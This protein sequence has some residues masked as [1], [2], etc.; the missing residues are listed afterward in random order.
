MA[1]IIVDD[2]IFSLE[3]LKAFLM[4]AGYLDIITVQSATELYELVDGHLERGIVEIDLILM[5][6]VMPEIDGIEACRNVKKR[7]WLV[8]VPVIMVTA[9]TEIDGLQLAFSAGAMDYIKK[10]L[11]RVELLARV[12]SALKLKYETY[13]RKA[14]EAEL[15]EVTCQ[16]KA[17]NERL[18]NLSFIDGLTGIANR[19]RFDEGLL[20]ECR[21]SKRENSPLSLIILDIDYFKAF[22]DTYGH[23]K[24]DDCLKKVASTLRQVLKRPGDFTA[25]YGGEEFAVVLPNTDDV[26]AAMIAEELRVR[27]EAANIMHIN[28]MIADHVTVSIGVVT[29]FPGQADTPDDLILAADRALYHS[30]HEGRNR[31]SVE[32]LV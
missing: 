30:K 12:R 21:R 5:D 22:N 27:I 23:L 31:V 4:S 3:V 8:D 29:R 24:G 1:I 14:R 2:T 25:R 19:R 16:L 32:R 18:Q 13:R 20:Q 26:G 6:V 11:D 28:S 10:P 17:A 15:L 7:E 9:T